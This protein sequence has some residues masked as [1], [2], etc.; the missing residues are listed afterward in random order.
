MR[1]LQAC[2]TWHPLIRLCC[3]FL[4]SG[5]AAGQTPPLPGPVCGTGGL[6]VLVRDSQ[7]S[8]I[9]DAQVTIS[10]PDGK[11]PATRATPSMGIADFDNVPCGDWLIRVVREGF[12]EARATASVT[13][14]AAVE[15]IVILN[16][17]ARHATLEV[18]D[19]A[20]PP[21]SQSATQNYELHPAE[22][23][24]LPGNPASVSDALPLVPGVVR[25][26]DGALKLDGSGEERSSLVVNQSDVTDPATG[27][28]GQTVPLDSIESLNVLSTPFLA[29]YGRFT[30][31]VVAVETKR[32][33][34]KWHADLNDPFPD[35]RIRSYHMRGIRNETPRASVGGPLVKDRLFF[36]T[37]LLYFLDK[38]PNRTLSFPY[39]ESKSERLN[40]FTQVDYIA[41]N[42]QIINASLHYTPEHTNFVNPEFFNPQPVTPSLAQKS[43]IGTAAHHLGVLNGT[44]DS[45]IAF[46]RFHTV[47]GAQGS[48]DMVLTP[49]GNRGN[50]FGTQNRD[51]GRNEWLELWSPAPLGMAGTHLPKVGSS[52]TTATDEGQ[53]NYRPIDILD[54]AGRRTQRIEFTNPLPY[55][56]QDLEYT[57][58]AQD[59]WS[60]HPR[61]SFDY[62]L[63]A[64]HQRLAESLRLAPRIGAAWTPFSDGRT[65]VRMGFGQ[66]Y[67]HIPL[68][69]YTF[70]RYPNRIIQS[71]DAAG[72]P[73]GPPEVFVNVIGDASGP[74]S[75]FIRSEQVAGAFSPRG[76]TWNV[77]IE[78]RFPKL[79]R[80]RGVYT[81]NRSVGLIVLQPDVLGATKEI[82]LNADGKS[83]YRQ[84]E[85][86]GRLSLRNDLEMVFSY[87][88]SRAEGNLNGFDSFIGNF[89]TP[90]VRENRYTN[91]AGD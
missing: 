14:T 81:D 25:S 64:E 60:P 43:W 79:L 7:D 77:Q 44:I 15:K 29:Q 66:F 51:A 75:F 28:F 22:V 82:V 56:R 53:F 91:L 20:P 88:R 72:Q 59:H 67:D 35:F 83:R 57:A 27:R 69:V 45:S 47:I 19:S 3:L 71:Y 38:S 8:P 21:V 52:L 23:K 37:S 49:T 31:T 16:P 11:E 26:P 68:D 40:S 9:F 87:T 61:I 90:L 1:R 73:E 46:Q 10:A 86:T 78:R 55:N 36:M 50:F 32:G 89:P 63:R 70:A 12:D 6:R 30:Q 58:Y 41:S 2:A 65:V 5:L 33:G 48:A 18:T 42:R 39:N 4:G 80:L 24:A 13:G 84:L 76:S 62:G 17:Q 54:A 74:R 34:D 85:L